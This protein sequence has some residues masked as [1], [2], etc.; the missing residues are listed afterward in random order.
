MS[1]GSLFVASWIAT[2]AAA[3]QAAPSTIGFSDVT[4]RQTVHV[5]LGGNALRVRLSN[6]YGDSPLLVAGASVLGR[7]VRFFGSP[8]VMIP[9]H[10][11]AI[12]DPVVMR[13][14]PESN[15]VIDL[16]IPGQTGT[17]TYH[18]LSY[19]T[20]FWASGDRLEQCNADGF[21]NSD[22]S[23]YF[24][25]GVDVRG[26]GSRG[27]VVALGDSITNGQ[28]STVNSN[29]R[30]PDDLAR[31]LLA[32][33][34][35]HRLG[36]VD[37]AID[38]NRLLR[39]RRAFGN[40]ALARFDSDVLSQDGVTAVIV[41][42]GI[43]DIQQK[44]HEYDARAIEFG[45]QQI[46]LRA[47]AHGLRVIGCTITPYAGW[48]TYEPAGEVTRLAVNAFIRSSGLFDGVADFDAVVRDPNDPQRLLPRYDS[49]DHLHPNA[50]A[51]RAMASTV[52]LP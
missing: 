41:L 13:V 36:V 1:I 48:P 3:P 49:G 33:P 30:W 46:G 28:G 7:R 14:A 45:L 15:L 25:T 37:L 21:V 11:D 23:W 17:A 51:Y 29:N 16:Y 2:W 34:Q 38:G 19:Q 22:R 47:H 31:R 43:N 24:F 6:R 4:L 40:D 27:T 18:H 42:L 32:L 52:P 50:T 12:S 10:A 35:K 20:T 5:S 44:P 39:E 9:P 26:S 8:S